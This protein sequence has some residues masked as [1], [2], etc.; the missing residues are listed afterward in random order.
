MVNHGLS[1][2][3]LFLLVGVL[4]E[5]RHTREIAA[6]GGIAGI[7]PVTTALF[8][9]ATFSSI[10]LPGLNGFVGEFLIL[11]GTWTSP[12]RW[13][14]V[15]GATGVILSAIYMLTMV[16]RVFWNPLV[17]EENRSLKEIRASELDPGGR[18]RR[19]HGLDRRPSE[20]CARSD[21][22]VRRCP[23]GVRRRAP[24]PGGR[25]YREAPSPLSRSAALTGLVQ[26]GPEEL[27]AVAPEIVLAAAGCVLVLLD[28]FLP[29]ARG[30]F[31]TFS[32]ASVA[33]SLA[34]LLRS[35]AGTFFGGRLETS[36][37]TSLAGL[38]IGATAAIAILVAKPYLRRTGE[39]RGEFYALLLWG[40]LGVSLL[41]RGLDLLVIFLGLE[42]LSLSFY[43]LA[44]FFRGIQA[45]SEA[46]LKYFLT[47]RV[48]VR[49]HPLRDRAS[50]RQ[51]RQPA[52]FRAVAGGSRVRS[53][54]DPR[55]CC[56]CSSG[57]GFKMS[58]APFHSWAPDV[59]QGMPT[60]AV[61][62]LSVAPKGASIL[63][64]YR[65]FAAVFQG[66][67]PDRIRDRR[68][69]DRDPLDD[70][71]QRRRARPA[72]R[73]AAARVLRHRADGIRDDRARGLRPKRARGG[74]RL[75]LRVPRVERGR[76]RRR[77]RPLSGRDETA[78]DR[79]A[80]RRGTA[81]A[82][83]RGRARS[84]PLLARGDPGDRGLHRKVLSLQG[85][86]RP[87]L[88]ALAIIGVVN[89]LDLDRLLPEGRLPDVHARPDRHGGA[90]AA[91][92]SPTAW[93]SASAE[94]AYSCSESFR[95]DS[96]TSPAAPPT[97]S[98]SSA[99]DASSPPRR[100]L[101]G[102]REPEG[103][104]HGRQPQAGF[105]PRRT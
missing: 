31:A 74:P 51:E 99:P 100:P 105:L 32:L 65:V 82:L 11:L 14:A 30:W 94:P 63:V 8:L 3:A 17:H 23:P 57:F 96:G 55:A 56:S 35:P 91:S 98:R 90:A 43:V 7:V 64:L 12:H 59:Y 46:G 103:G 95:R 40:H 53:A 86:D 52:A 71:R 102:S 4:Y 25:G 77:R 60:P 37:L 76:L 58:V 28:A 39:E 29:R 92:A 73:Q 41:T 67:L 48:R 89:S 36:P 66:G 54:R 45:S 9:V 97:R 87:G 33:G 19:P 80:R 75:L 20:R 22:P 18:P 83:R 26:F 93:P 50:F 47:G 78:P 1:T 34:L 101:S 69:R 61:T 24:L 79:S 27:A 70:V 84:L 44:A 49:V 6:Y 62:Y 72:R 68:R 81:L 10:G 85:G 16:Q 104:S 88:Y 38:F 42:L 2:G 15:V 13:W 21:P 5:R